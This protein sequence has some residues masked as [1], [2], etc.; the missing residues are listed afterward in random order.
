MRSLTGL[1]DDGVGASGRRFMRSLTGLTDD[2][3]GACGRRFVRSFTGLTDDGVGACGRRFMPSFA[4]FT[5]DGAG[6]Y[7]RRFVRSC[8]GLPVEML[9]ACV[10]H[11]VLWSRGS[12]T[13]R[14]RRVCT[15]STEGVMPRLLGVVP[16]KAACVR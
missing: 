11:A 1:P 9:L 5:D 14:L 2:G 10:L 12:L 7:R 16:R 3:A 13:D 15:T 6:E 8:M 4:G